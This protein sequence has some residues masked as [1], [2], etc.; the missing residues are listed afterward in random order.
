MSGSF[1]DPSM[2]KA[3]VS[4]A[5]GGSGDRLRIGMLGTYPPTECG[6]ATFAAALRTGMSHDE[7]GQHNCDVVRLVDRPQ[8]DGGPAVVAELQRGSASSVAAAVEALNQL[9]AT[10]I[11]HEYGIFG[12]EDG[13]EVLEIVEDLEGPVIVVLHTVLDDPSPNQRRIIESLASS[14]DA[15]VTMTRTAQRRLRDYDLDMAKVSVIPHGA[16]PPAPDLEVEADPEAPT[17]LTWGLLGP[18]K[19]IEWVVEAMA[20]LKDLDNP[21]RYQ[22]VGKTHPKVLEE[23]GEQYRSSLEERAA[24]LGVAHLVEFVDNYS[25]RAELQ[26]RIAA[27][28][29]V[30][31]PYDSEDQV[32]SG[33]LVEAVASSKA[34][35]SSSFPHAVELL[36]GG[37]GL[38]VPRHDPDAIAEAL[39]RILSDPALH[40]RMVDGA[41]A[42]APSLSWTAVGD[43]YRSLADKLLRGRAT[44]VA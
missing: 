28:H 39:R 44:A 33:V 14:V 22:V 42:L 26:R 31:L 10:I 38:L 18:G 9:D 8:G 40:Q 12:S 11:Q 30:V 3:G 25:D 16:H 15:L 24:E 17:I 41:A 32:T 23:H 1:T 13:E 21:P 20:Q 35:I 43:Q 6:L 34:V 2:R 5:S 36:G 19:G 29:V 7:S 27:A 37:V 4:H